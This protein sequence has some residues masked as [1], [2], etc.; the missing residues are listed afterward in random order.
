LV[1]AAVVPC[2]AAAREVVGV[3]PIELRIVEEEL[4]ALAVGFVGEHLEGI[5]LVRGALDDVP[6]GKLGVEHG[7]TVVVAGSDGDVLHA[8]GFGQSDPGFGVELFGVEEVGQTFVVVEPELAVVE[9]PFTV[10]EDAVDA[11][12]DEQAELVVLEFLAGFEVFRGGLV[13]VLGGGGKSEESGDCENE[14]NFG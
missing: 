14:R 9:N 5:F 6:V 8:G 11:P 2:G 12:V 10:A 7:E 13:G 4:D 3:V 1:G